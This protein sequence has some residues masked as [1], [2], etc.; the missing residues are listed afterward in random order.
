MQKQ[1][2]YPFN[3]SGFTCYSYAQNPKTSLNTLESKIARIAL[4]AGS[5]GS[6]VIGLNIVNSG[7]VA[8]GYIYVSVNNGT[9]KRCRIENGV[10]FGT[11]LSDVTI[12]QNFFSGVT[13]TNCLATNGNVFFIAPTD[14]IFNNNI[15]QKTL[16]W[17]HRLQTQLLP[18]QFYNVKI[19]C[20]MARIIWQHPTL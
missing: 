16:R 8:D 12:V 1:F 6:Q 10:G 4:N 14:I 13:N 7:N 15:C 20:L 2:I 11:Q 19:M 17:E 5:E 3:T 9:V 18:G